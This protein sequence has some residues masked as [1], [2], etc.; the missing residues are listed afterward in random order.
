MLTPHPS[1]NQPATSLS[2]VAMNPNSPYDS[3][4][5]PASNITP[6]SSSISGSGDGIV[7]KNVNS[8]RTGGPQ[9]PGV[10]AL[11][12][13][14]AANINLAGMNVT[15]TTGSNKVNT[16]ASVVAGGIKDEG[17]V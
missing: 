15:A 14:A 5:L 11:P 1:N 17:I 4:S 9:Q 13:S 12:A 6:S 10:Y 2:S 8:M 16:F 3:S 7:S